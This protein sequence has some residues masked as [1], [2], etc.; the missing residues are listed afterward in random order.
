VVSA[1][2]I[3]AATLSKADII[4]DVNLRVVNFSG[5]AVTVTGTITT[6]GTTG[7]SLTYG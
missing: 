3:S 1:I 7:T 5:T 2:T 6:H 4:Y